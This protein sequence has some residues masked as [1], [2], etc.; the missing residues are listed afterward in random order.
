MLRYFLVF[1]FFCLLNSAYSSAKVHLSQ[2]MNDSLTPLCLNDKLSTVQL[3]KQIVQLLRTESKS[4]YQQDPFVYT[5]DD[6]TTPIENYIAGAKGD[7]ATY[8]FRISQILQFAHQY[9]CKPEAEAKS[10]GVYTIYSLMNALQYSAPEQ[11]TNLLFIIGKAWLIPCMSYPETLSD[12]NISSLF[13]AAVEDHLILARHRG[14]AYYPYACSTLEIFI[15]KY[16]CKDKYA[17]ARCYYWLSWM[18][19]NN[20]QY[21][22]STAAAKKIPDIKEMKG[23]QQRLSK[24]ANAQRKKSNNK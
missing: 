20:N 21:A 6:Y 7:S 24:W 5:N 1:I 13:A 11:Q 19:L 9:L 16:F 15:P 2:E 23:A 4:T 3:Q 10:L 12:K 22:K 17:Q 14:K 18:Y 8:C